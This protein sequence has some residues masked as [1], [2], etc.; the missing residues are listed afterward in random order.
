MVFAQAAHLLKLRPREDVGHVLQHRVPYLR[1]PPEGRPDV[2]HQELHR[3]GQADGR[4]PAELRRGNLD[5]AAVLAGALEG[6][7]HVVW[8]R[9][10]ND[11]HAPP[12]RQLEKARDEASARRVENVDLTD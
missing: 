9:I 12:A 7:R 8:C 5:D 10:E 11:V 6:L 2:E 3:L 4:R 1:A